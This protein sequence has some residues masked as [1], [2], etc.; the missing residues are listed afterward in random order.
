MVQY[1]E[2]DR[3]TVNTLTAEKLLFLIYLVT[4]LFHCHH[5]K[6]DV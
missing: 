2:S 5:T 1:I 3:H 6:S 4:A